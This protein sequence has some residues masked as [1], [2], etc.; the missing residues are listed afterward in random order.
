MRWLQNLVEPVKRSPPPPAGHAAGAAPDV[1]RPA[2]SLP[3][4][5]IVSIDVIRGV[6]IAGILLINIS[7]FLSRAGQSPASRGTD[8]VIWQV[9]DV[10]ALGKF[11]FVF[12]FLFGTGVFIFLSRLRAKGRSRW[13]Y[14]RHAIS[15]LSNLQLPSL[16]AVVGF[17]IGGLLMTWIFLPNIL[18]F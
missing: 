18:Q 17:F 13:V 15:G 11:H 7:Y 1:R 3:A 10:L 9:V 8:A 2:P 14:I 6:A 16:I 4:D 5:R 12:A